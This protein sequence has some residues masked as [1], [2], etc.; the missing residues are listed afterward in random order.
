MFKVIHLSI[1]F[2]KITSSAVAVMVLEV[3]MDK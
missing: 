2:Q 1:P 3:V